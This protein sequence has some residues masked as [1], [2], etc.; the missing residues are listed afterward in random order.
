M[1]RY[2]R[3]SAARRS[4]KHDRLVS[5]LAQE[6][7]TAGESL[8]PLILEDHLPVTKS[9]HV[10]VIWD[11]WSGIP[12]E[13]RATI[14]VDAYAKAE[15]EPAASEV[16]VADGV[17]PQEALALGLLPFK[18]VPACKRND[19]VPAEAYDAALHAEARNTVLGG[20]ARELRYARVE[21]ADQG[22]ARLE[23]ALPRSRWAVIQE[24]ETES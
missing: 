9:R 6:F 4:P 19:P 1:P 16:T 5:R 20:K 10:H 21:D 15:G 14:I 11:A 2:I 3:T 8:M 7:R 23:R 18:V 17:T 24:V 22:C 13:D 12:D